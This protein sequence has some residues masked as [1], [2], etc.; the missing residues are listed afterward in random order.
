MKVYNN[1][2]GSKQSSLPLII[3]KDTIYVHSNIILIS[4]EDDLYQYDEIQYTK[5]E[6]IKLLS[7]QND[8]L[9]SQI[10]I[11]KEVTDTLLFN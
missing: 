1:I 3:G 9:S 8:N 11:L 10:N 2:K 4:E 6:Y 5:D 7:E